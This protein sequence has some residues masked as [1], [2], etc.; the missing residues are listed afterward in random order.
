MLQQKILQPLPI[1]PSSGHFTRR[2]SNTTPMLSGRRLEL[3]QPRP[4]A[5][6]IK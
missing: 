6:A 1:V 4:P 3:N 2:W 5:G